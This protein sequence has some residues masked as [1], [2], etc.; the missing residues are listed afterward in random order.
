MRR[1][2]KITLAALVGVGVLYACGPFIA[3][4]FAVGDREGPRL[5]SQDFH[6]RIYDFAY[7][8]RTGQKPESSLRNVLYDRPLFYGQPRPPKSMRQ[9]YSIL[10]NA[11]VR[12]LPIRDQLYEWNLE[13]DKEAETSSGGD[14]APSRAPPM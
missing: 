14:A 1:G 10:A 4:V 8:A 12:K 5:Y 6:T 9:R 13:I 11:E 3:G 7:E 2:L